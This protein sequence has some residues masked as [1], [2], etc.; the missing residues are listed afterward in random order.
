MERENVEEG[1]LPEGDRGK[2]LELKKMGPKIL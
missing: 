1:I 2:I